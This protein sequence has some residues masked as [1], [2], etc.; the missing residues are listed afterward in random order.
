MVAG[1]LGSGLLLASA[2]IERF[3]SVAFPLKVQ[4]W[5]MYAKTKVLMV[6]YIVLAFSLSSYALLCVEFQPAT[7][8]TSETCVLAEQYNDVCFLSDVI[9]I[10]AFS[11]SLCSFLILMFTILISAYLFRLRKA[12]LEMGKKSAK[13]FQ[14]TLMLVMVAL[15]FYNVTNSGNGIIPNYLLQ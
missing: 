12:R 9:I 4:Q 8:N 2:T 6:A 1:F 7:S 5:K 3:L 10:I 15:F 11:N 13:E 14:I